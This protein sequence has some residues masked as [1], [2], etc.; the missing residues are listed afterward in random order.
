[1]S[2]QACLPMVFPVL[3]AMMPGCDVFMPDWGAWDMPCNDDGDCADGYR[4]S[5]DRCIEKAACQADGECREQLGFEPNGSDAFC[6][7]YDDWGECDLPLLEMF[8]KDCKP[9]NEDV[10]CGW[11]G[12][13]LC[14]CFGTGPA[15]NCHCTRECW[16]AE[17]CGSVAG[18]E[19]VCV[20]REDFSGMS[21]CADVYWI[22]DR[23]FGVHCDPAEGLPCPYGTE[24]LDCVNAGHLAGPICTVSCTPPDGT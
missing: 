5:F 13:P 10:D 17:K 18:T 3:L 20:H 15:N 22:G 9:E 4:C 6:T 11:S 16:P 24:S 14:A 12:Y 1:M 7:M 19:R 21:V 8:G 23:A 2:R